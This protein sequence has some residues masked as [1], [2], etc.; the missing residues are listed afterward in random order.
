LQNLNFSWVIKELSQE[1]SALFLEQVLKAATELTP[2]LPKKR[3][4]E[5]QL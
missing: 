3:L 5:S 1:N 4:A 2:Q